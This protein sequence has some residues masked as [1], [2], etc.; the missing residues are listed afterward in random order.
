MNARLQLAIL[1]ER[2]DVAHRAAL[3]DDGAIGRYSALKDLVVEMALLLPHASD[4]VESTFPQGGE[5]LAI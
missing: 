2:L 5:S 1:V 3:A 4:A